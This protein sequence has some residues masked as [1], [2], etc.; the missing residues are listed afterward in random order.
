MIL[1]E[2][3][4]NAQKTRID[5]AL[6]E[7]FFGI[8]TVGVAKILQRGKRLFYRHSGKEIGIHRVYNRVIFDELIQKNATYNFHFRDELEVEWVGHPNW[9]FK[10]SKFILPL[11]HNQYSPECFYLSDLTRYPKDL[12]NYVLKPLFSFAGSGV[13]IDISE[14]ILDSIKN[15]TDYI[16]QQ[17]VDYAP[18]L[19][20]P[21]K[22]ASAEVRMIYFWN[23]KLRLMTNHVRV[24]KGQMMGVDFNK[25]Q[26]WVGSTI[27]YHSLF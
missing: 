15:R 9:F 22:P 4:P 12:H 17:K 8:K 24:S 11:L 2:V 19:K 6:T 5:F 14:S 27:G 10:I 3:N 1:L 23:D 7:Q 21:G 18:F 16:L 13:Q 20:T 25:R 26:K